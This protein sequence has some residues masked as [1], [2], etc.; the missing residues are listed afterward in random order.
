MQHEKEKWD[1]DKMMY[2]PKRRR[3]CN[4]R[5]IQYEKR[6]DFVITTRTDPNKEG[7]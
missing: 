6:I 1:K 5:T 7:Q 3:V 2:A 4:M